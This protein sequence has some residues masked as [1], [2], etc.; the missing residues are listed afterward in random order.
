MVIILIM[1]ILIAITTCQIAVDVKQKKLL[2]GKTDACFFVSPSSHLV[3]SYFSSSFPFVTPIRGHIAGACPPPP[4]YDT[5][6]LFIRE[7]RSGFS[8][9]V[10]S[11]R[12]VHVKNKT[13][14]Q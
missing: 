10:D 9:C 1:N 6:L 2:P 12:I 4:H 3:V 14:F 7:K 11:R 5:R 8:S 13:V